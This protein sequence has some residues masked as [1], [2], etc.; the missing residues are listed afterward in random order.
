MIIIIPHFI[1]KLLYVKLAN[2]NLIIGD[3]SIASIIHINDSK[4]EE[5]E[6]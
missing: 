1:I 4:P 3:A 5:L 2:S 6:N